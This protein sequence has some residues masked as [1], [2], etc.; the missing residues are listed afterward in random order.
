MSKYT[1]KENYVHYT[2][3]V[4]AVSLLI[5]DIKVFLKLFIP[6]SEFKCTRIRVHVVSTNGIIQTQ[7]LMYQQIGIGQ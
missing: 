7:R 5:E 2:Y 1:W 6:L 3:L 4:T